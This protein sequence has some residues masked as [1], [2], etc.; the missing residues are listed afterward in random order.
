[1]AEFR[2]RIWA[3]QTLFDSRDYVVQAA[4]LEE[5][6]ARLKMVQEDAQDLDAS[7]EHDDIDRPVR[8]LDPSEVV[9]SYDGVTLIDER[10]NRLR[11]L[12]GVPT[13]CVKLGE[14]IDEIELEF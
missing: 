1:M 3:E 9:E 12:V 11:D 2:L 4:T 6:V 10:G 8:L 5:A 13:G 14:E 7:T